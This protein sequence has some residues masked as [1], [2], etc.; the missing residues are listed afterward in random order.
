MTRFSGLIP[1]F[2]YDLQVKP[3]YCCIREHIAGN[4]VAG[5]G[6]CIGIRI[7]KPSG[8]RVVIAGLEVIEAGFRI[9]IAV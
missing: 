4:S 3:D 5:I 6:T 8:C 1:I 7:D 9:V 2:H